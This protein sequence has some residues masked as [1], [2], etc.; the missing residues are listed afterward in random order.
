MEEVKKE[1]P[2]KD[3]SWI[4]KGLSVR[5]GKYTHPESTLTFSKNAG[6]SGSVMKID[7][8]YAVLYIPTNNLKGLP[9]Q[10][11]VPLIQCEQA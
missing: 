7:G 1:E 10:E 6:A 3:T 11:K 2:L 9:M 4:H 8:E 5:I